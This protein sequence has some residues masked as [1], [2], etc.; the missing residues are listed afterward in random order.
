METVKIRGK[1]TN[2]ESKFEFVAQATDPK[3][4]IASVARDVVQL[5]L[6]ADKAEKIKDGGIFYSTGFELRP[7]ITS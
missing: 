7:A 6:P 2:R 3:G 5:R 1:G 4:K